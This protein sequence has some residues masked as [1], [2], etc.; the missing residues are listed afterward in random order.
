VAADRAF[1]GHRVHRQLHSAHG[2]AAA[3]QRLPEAARRRQD[4][5]RLARRRRPARQLPFPALRES[6]G[7]EHARNDGQAE[8]R[9][10]RPAQ[11]DPQR[12]ARH[13]QVPRRVVHVVSGDGRLRR[14]PHRTHGR[15]RRA[16]P[17]G[18]SRGGH[19]GLPRLCRRAN[20][21]LHLEGSA[22]EHHLQARLR[23]ADLRPAPSAGSGPVR[24]RDREPGGFSRQTPRDARRALGPPS[25]R[26]FHR[27]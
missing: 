26:L 20:Q 18:V 21:R 7:N 9:P 15:P 23:F 19:G 6:Q 27:S 1:G 5:G 11:R 25:P 24:T 13:G 22:L 2:P 16:L 10:G 17:G 3:S 4:H 8:G 14:L 12:P